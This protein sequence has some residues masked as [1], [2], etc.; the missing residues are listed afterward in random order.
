MIS[1]C[2]LS[3]L[4]LFCYEMP[5]HAKK[6]NYIRSHCQEYA[7]KW[8]IDELETS[9][10]FSIAAK[11]LLCLASIYPTRILPSGVAWDNF[12]RYVEL[13]K[14]NGRRYRYCFLYK[15]KLNKNNLERHSYGQNILIIVRDLRGRRKRSYDR[16]NFDN[17]NHAKM[18]EI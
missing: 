8:K 17:L 4:Y 11:K 15:Q 18:R 16:G 5:Y 13:S 12:D 9:A 3:R 14:K 10:A 1:Y 6:A 2:F 7:R